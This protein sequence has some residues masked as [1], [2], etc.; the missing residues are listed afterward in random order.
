[1]RR[2]DP[3]LYQKTLGHPREYSFYVGLMKG[4]ALFISVFSVELQ[5]TRGERLGFHGLV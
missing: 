4:V 5:L 3:K 2:Y 1:V